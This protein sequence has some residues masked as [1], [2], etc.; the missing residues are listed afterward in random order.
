MG[1]PDDE[2]NFIKKRKESQPE[3]FN[4]NYYQGSSGLGVHPR[5]VKF[6]E[7]EVPKDPN[8]LALQYLR[9]EELARRNQSLNHRSLPTHIK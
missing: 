2:F 3:L 7:Q 1:H 8:Q 9:L 4:I 6:G 5:Q